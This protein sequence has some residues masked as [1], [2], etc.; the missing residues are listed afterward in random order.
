MWA[1]LRTGLYSNMGMAGM[2]MAEEMIC[3]LKN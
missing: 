1:V 2:Q 3:Q